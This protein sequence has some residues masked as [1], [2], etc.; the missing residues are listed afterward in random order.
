RQAK[1]RG[2]WGSIGRF[3]SSDRQQEVPTGAGDVSGNSLLDFLRDLGCS[4]QGNLGSF[5]GFYG[6]QAKDAAET[7]K[8]MGVYDRY[9]SDLHSPDHAK[10]VLGSPGLR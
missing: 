3:V 10:V 4:F 1:N 8:S 7:L 6:V 2:F 5:N 9:G